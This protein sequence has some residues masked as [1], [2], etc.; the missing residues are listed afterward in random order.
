MNVYDAISFL[1]FANWCVYKTVLATQNKI[2]KTG[3]CCDS[4]PVRYYYESVK[5]KCQK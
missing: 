1:T 2:R 3:M 4:Q 5:L